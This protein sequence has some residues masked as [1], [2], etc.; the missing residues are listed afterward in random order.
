MLALVGA[1]I[2]ESRAFQAYSL[3]R[4]GEAKI[5]YTRVINTAVGTAAQVARASY[6]TY[7]FIH[8]HTLLISL[9][10]L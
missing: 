6:V 2:S 10:S 9:L 5:T 1:Y 7:S 4:G 3:E 8:Y